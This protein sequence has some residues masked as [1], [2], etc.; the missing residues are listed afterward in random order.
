MNSRLLV[1]SGFMFLLGAAAGAAGMSLRGGAEREAAVRAA[2]FQVAT[3][4]QLARVEQ[5]CGAQVR[6]GSTD[7]AAVAGL[8]SAQ[9]R[10]SL[11]TLEARTASSV[12]NLGENAKAPN[13]AR[14]E[15]ADSEGNLENVVLAQKLLDDAV[16]VRRWTPENRERMRTFLASMPASERDQIMVSMAHHVNLGELVP[17]DSQPPY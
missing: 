9:L 17:T 7:P 15:D 8:V 2:A 10:D 14:G 3:Q 1:I 16:S 13:P 4:Q 6:A 5:A 11:A 12:A